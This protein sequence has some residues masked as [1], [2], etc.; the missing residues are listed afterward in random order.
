MFF[1]TGSSFQ[2]GPERISERPPYTQ[3]VDWHALYPNAICLHGPRKRRQ[4]ALTFD[5]GPDNTWT[6]EILSVLSHFNVKATF[7]CVGQQVYYYPEVFHRI[8]QDGHIVENHSWDHPNFTKIP[9]SEARSQI[10]RTSSLMEQIVAIRPA[11]FR[12]PYG[13]INQDVIKLVLSLRNRILYWDVDSLDWEGLTG[14]QVAANVLAH[15]RAGSIVLMHFAGGKEG[16]LQGTV[17]ALPRIITTL[18]REGFSFLT[19]SNLLNVPAYL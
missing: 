2:H 6:P 17:Q 12:P 19:V 8:I 13:A 14:K 11:L 3:H 16:N 15:A 9:L 7:N 18:Q 10:E 4:I 1:N 5:D